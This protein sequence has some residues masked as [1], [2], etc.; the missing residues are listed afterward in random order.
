MTRITRFIRLVPI[1]AIIVWSLACGS[2]HLPPAPGPAPTPVPTPAP[3]HVD[4]LTWPVQCSDIWQQELFRPIDQAGLSGCLEQ[5]RRG[6][7]GE[8]IRAGVRASDEWKQAHQPKPPEPAKPWETVT[9]AQLRAWRGS[10]S[11]TLA[12]MP[13]G[14]RPNQP[15]NVMFTALFDSSCWTAA[16]RARALAAYTA[17]S[18]THWPIGPIESHGYH[19]LNP[20]MSWVDNPDGFADR[21][22]EL[23]RGGKIPVFFALPDT[24]FC[25]DGAHI[26][27]DCVERRLTPIYTSPRFQ[28]LVRIAVAAW[29]PEYS[30]ADEVWAAQWLARVFPK[31]YR[32]LHLPSGHSAPCLGSEL[33]EGG[34][35]IRD[36]GA[37]WERVAPY[38]HFYLQQETWTFG[39][40]AAPGRTG[41]QQFLYNVWDTSHRFAEG[42]WPA[43]GADG[44]PIDVVAFEYASYYVTNDPARAK[45]ADEWGDA[46]IASA[47]FTDSVTGKT[48]DPA[49]YLTGYGDGGTVDP[50]TRPRFTFSLVPTEERPRFSFTFQR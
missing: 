32:G 45:E 28:A 7:S 47:P 39:G 18:W 38:I 37:C 16:D 40:E 30:S 24:G 11:T 46:A 23:W 15:T 36:E 34:G 25:A 14:P 10:I 35:S 13:C 26:D 29:E 49:R 41:K 22:E 4:D 6:D 42:S 3:I 1:A 8:Q 33:V 48:I 43:K 20:D 44:K 2:M 31:A 21:L 12:P 17:K 9:D 19:S 5:F 50:L 27:R